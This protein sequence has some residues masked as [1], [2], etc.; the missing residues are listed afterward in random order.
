MLPPK[1]FYSIIIRLMPAGKSELK[2]AGIVNLFRLSF[3]ANAHANIHFSFDCALDI[4]CNW[5]LC[6]K[7]A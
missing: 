2:I 1:P 7:V 6:R 3:P 4:I 5:N